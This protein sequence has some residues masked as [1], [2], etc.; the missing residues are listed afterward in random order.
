MKLTFAKLYRR[1]KEGDP[2][3]PSIVAFA[4]VPYE[5]TTVG[6]HVYITQ[7]KYFL[8]INLW[9]IEIHHIFI[10]PAHDVKPYD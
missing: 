6:D 9:L 8:Y 7:Y 2:Y 1:V 3:K 5:A 10:K 4:K